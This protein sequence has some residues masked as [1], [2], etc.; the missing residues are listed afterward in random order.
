MVV[1]NLGITNF[2]LRDLYYMLK[3]QTFEAFS[4]NKL[5]LKELKLRPLWEKDNIHVQ[6]FTP[7]PKI[8]LKCF[9]L[10]VIRTKN[11]LVKI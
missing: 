4:G 2:I 7:F 1:S 10:M 8:F 11:Y 3:L 5:W 6:A 9:L